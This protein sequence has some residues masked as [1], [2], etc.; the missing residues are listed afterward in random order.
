MK[1]TGNNPSVP[2]HN[3]CLKSSCCSGGR[4][5]APMVVLQHGRAFILVHRVLSIFGDIRLGPVSPTQAWLGRGT[6]SPPLQ[7]PVSPYMFGFPP[8]RGFGSYL[9]GG[10]RRGLHVRPQVPPVPPADQQGVG[11]P[12]C[13]VPPGREGESR[14]APLAFSGLIQG[15][16]GW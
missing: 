10:G 6:N 3:E 9:P 5:A 4:G 11:Q 1:N 8:Q 7:G 12:P 14:V 16:A 13:S 15:V 2:G